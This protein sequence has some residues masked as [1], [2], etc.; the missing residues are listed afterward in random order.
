MNIDTSDGNV[1]SYVNTGFWQSAT[2]TGG[3]SSDKAECFERDYKDVDVFNNVLASQILIVCHEEGKVLGWRTWKLLETKSLHSWFN[4]GNTCP[5]S[6]DRGRRVH[7]SSETTGG[8]VGTLINNEPL[9]K[10]TYD[11][12]GNLWI[13]THYGSSDYNRIQTTANGGYNRGAG[14]GTQY[15][16]DNCGNTARPMA[17]AVLRTD[18]EHWG[19]NGGIGGLVGTDHTCNGGCPWTVKSGVKWDYAI[20]VM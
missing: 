5:G 11:G 4:Q 15:D 6:F 13:N 10:N 7:M 14:L 20:F 17:D 2:E 1:L 19:S 9:I 16:Q 8:D 12:V 3:A 18:R